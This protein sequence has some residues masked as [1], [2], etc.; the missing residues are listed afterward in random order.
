MHLLYTSTS[1]EFVQ[2]IH[3]P[4]EYN[5]HN[6]P[7]RAAILSADDVRRNENA[8]CPED[9]G[10]LLVS[11]PPPFCVPP[12][13]SDTWFRPCR[14]PA[15]SVLTGLLPRHPS[16][17]F[18]DSDL[19]TDLPD[20]GKI[21]LWRQ[22]MQAGMRMAEEYL[23]DPDPEFPHWGLHRDESDSFQFPY[24]SLPG[25][26]DGL[27]ITRARIRPLFRDFTW[28][29]IAHHLSGGREPLVPQLQQIE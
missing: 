4:L 3:P 19:A 16:D 23:L 27:L 1:C 2:D 24:D 29:T 15:G 6:F 18:L 21:L 14:Q 17:L 26:S 13:Y 28:D 11:T 20:F 7:R 25:G 9:W 12:P 5:D 8:Q 22:I 10:V